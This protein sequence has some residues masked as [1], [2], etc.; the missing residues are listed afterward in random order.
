MTSELCPCGAGQEYDECCGRFHRGEADA[1]TAEALMRARYSAFAVGDAE[2]LR[3][4]WHRSTRPARA[5]PPA[6]LSWI[7]LDVL[8]ISGG[9]VFDTAGTVEF[10]AH[11]K[12]AGQ[13]G[14]QHDTSRFVRE[15][16]RWLYVTEV[17]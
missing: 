15:R 16:G 7:R 12:I 10:E 13:L 8:S 1:P 6:D 2:Y 11:Y 17:P 3:D 5:I 14:V 9:G 4:T